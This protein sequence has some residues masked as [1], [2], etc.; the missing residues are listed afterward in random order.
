MMK[1]RERSLLRELSAIELFLTSVN[2]K[3]FRV[4]LSSE[5]IR[6]AGNE[7]DGRMFFR[8]EISMRKI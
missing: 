6:E 1:N 2:N 3:K 4:R 7:V 8:V 5:N